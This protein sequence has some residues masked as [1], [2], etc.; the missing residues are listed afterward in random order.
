MP[1][2]ESYTDEDIN[3]IAEWLNN[4]TFRQLMFL[5]DSYEAMLKEQAETFTYGKNQYVQ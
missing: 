1:D 4:L 2:Y 3:N 5:K